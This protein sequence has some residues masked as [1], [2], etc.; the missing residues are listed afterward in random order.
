GP[1]CVAASP[2]KATRWPLSGR[3]VR[4]HC[5]QETS[6]KDARACCLA[7]A[8][9][10][11]RIA[12][13]APGTPSTCPAQRWIVPPA[14]A[15]PTTPTTRPAPQRRWIVPPA[16]ATPTTPTTCP[17]RQRRCGTPSPAAR[18]KASRPKA[19]PRMALGTKRGPMQATMQLRNMRKQL[20]RG[21]PFGQ[22]Q[23]AAGA[24]RVS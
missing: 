15:T 13:A 2:P 5:F 23:H 10:K 22:F 24:E 1:T 12:Q 6:R 14:H 3:R 21:A 4:S 16:R 8:A 20:R 19:M 11:R 7:R 18:S 9:L 17:A